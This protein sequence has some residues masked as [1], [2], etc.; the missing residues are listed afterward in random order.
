MKTLR[1]LVLGLLAMAVMQPSAGLAQTGQPASPVAEVVTPE[2]QA[3]ARGLQND[4]VQIFNFVHD[5]IR[6]VFYFGSKKGAEITLLEKSGN[7]FDQCAL[8]VALLRAAGYSPSYEFGVLEMPYDATDGTHN[9][10]HHWL[11]L[12]LVNTNWSNTLDYFGSLIGQRGYP[13]FLDF[14]DGNT[15]G[16]QRVWVVVVI[17]GTTYHLDPGFKVSEPVAGISLTNATG[18]STSGLLSAAGGTDTGNYVTNLNEANIRATLTGYTTNLLN[19]LQNNTPN[20]SVQ[21]VLGGWQIVPATNT[22]LSQNLLFDEDSIDLPIVGWSNE[23]TNLMTSFSIAFAGTNYQWRMPQLEGQRISLTYS[24]NGV[25]QLW[26]DDSLLVQKSTVASDT[27]FVLTINHPFGYWDYTTNGLVDTGLDDQATT[28]VCQRTSSTYVMA[29]AFEPDW[30]WLHK[31]QNQLDAYRMSGMTNGSRQVVSET[32]NILGLSWV[33][34]TADVNQI[35]ASQMSML[36]QNHHTIGRVGQE[37]AGFFID[38]HKNSGDFP[39]SGI[40]DAVSQDNSIREPDLAAYFSSA[41]ESGIIEQLQPTN[42]A[43]STVKMLEIANTNHQAVFLASI[44][45]WATG[46]NV[47]NQLLGYDAG[48][49]SLLTA[50]VNAGFYI[51]LPKSGTN[52]VGGTGSWAGYGLVARY[53]NSTNLNESLSMLITGGYNGGYS[54][55]SSGIDPDAVDIFDDSYWDYFLT[56]PPWTPDPTGADPVD[57]SDGTFQVEHTDLSIGQTE[58]RGITLTRYYNGA[59]RNSNPV[60]MAGGWLHNY[61]INATTVAA[62][63][64]ALGGMSPQHMASMIAAAYAAAN[65]YSSTPNAKNWMVTALVAKW[66]IDQLKNNG[67]SVAMGKDVVEF[68]KQPNGIFSPPGNCTMTLTQTNSAYNLQERHGNTFK[69]DSLGRLTNIVDQYSQPLTISYNAS[70][71]VSTVKDWKSRTFTFNYSGTPQRLTSVSDGTRTINYGYGTTYSAQGD[72]ISFTD[73]ESKTTTYTY[74]TNHQ[75][76][77]TLDGLSRLVVSNLYDSQGHITTQYTQ[78]DTNKTWQI[79][80]SGWQTAEQDPAGSQRIFFYDDQARLIGVQDQLLHL[81]QTLYD[82]QNHLTMTVSPL[83]ETNQYIYDSNNNLTY[84]VDPLG[85]TNQYLYDNQNNLVKTIDPRG[86]ISTFGYNSQFSLTG[87]TNGAGDFVTS[88]YNSDGTLAN[89]TDSG[90]T[91][92]FNYDA[93]GQLNLVTYPS[94]LGSESFGNSVRGDVTNHTDARNFATA[95]QYNNRRELTNTIA[96]TNLMVKVSFDAA[97][98]VANITDPRGNTATRTWSA[99]RH[100]LATTM[101]PTPQ[102]TPVVTNSY[103]SRDWLI[104]M[105]DP[106]QNPVLY[107]ND[108]TGRL[109]SKTDPAQRTTTFSYD[110]DG[111]KLTSV[112]A[113]GET[114]SQTWDVRGG[115]LKLTDGA[116]HFSTRAYDAAGNQIILTNRNGKKWQFQFDGANRLTNTITPLGHSTSRAFNHQGLVASL[117]DPAGQ[118]TS[119]GYDAKGRLTNRTDNIATTLLSYDAN[120]NRTSVIESSKTNAWTYDAYNRISTYR[121]TSGNL[122]QYRYDANGNVTNLIYPGNRTV[123]YFYDSVNR[124]TNVMDWSGRKTSFAYDLNNRVTSIIRPNGTFRTINYDAAGQTTN[125]LEQTAIG[126]PIALFR[127]NWNTAAE[128]QWEFAAPLPHTNAPPTRTMTYNDDNQLATFN[129][130]PVTSDFDGNLT[131][132]PLTNSTFVTYTYDIRNRLSDAG[133]VT[134]SYDAMNS[135]IG[136]TYGTNAA[137]FVINPN[138][139]LPQVLMRI[140][141]GVTNYYIYGLGLLY[142]ITETT[143]TTNTLTYHYDYR[144]STIALSADNGLVTDRIEYSLYGSTTYR[145]GTNDTPFL[146]NGRYGVQTDPNGLL[147]MRA[148]YYNPYLCRFLNP[149]PTGFSGGMNFYT[150]ANGN[151]VNLID[152]FGLG[153]TEPSGNSWLGDIFR[154]IPIIGGLLGGVGDVLSGVGN[155]L[156]GLGTFGQSG[157]LNTGLNQFGQGLANSII[158]SVNLVGSVWTLPNTAIGFVAGGVSFLAGEVMGTHPEFHIANNAFQFLNLPFGPGGAL[159]LGNTQLYNNA[160]PTTTGPRYDGGLGDVVFG[161]HEEGHT[162]Q[163]ELLGPFFLPVYF[164]SGGISANNPLENSADDYSQGVGSWWPW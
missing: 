37:S 42:T 78:G 58:P 105:V 66:G 161:P 91:T 102:G 2:I 3:L 45:N 35:L 119:L 143:T 151:P 147:Y 21:Q 53:F 60:G 141:N 137:T 63:W 1:I 68:V 134:N 28:N 16:I 112:N 160:D 5:H 162:Y 73:A 43:A 48:T 123:T 113:A 96:P 31:R 103:D 135:R 142:Q 11:Q 90:G 100:L 99:T 86:N 69:F 114:N 67:V 29:Y 56:T 20:A 92:Q 32:L 76:T 25:A 149:D 61:N 34:E 106:L 131:S 118:T 87:Q 153:A 128:A 145:A 8:L 81:T 156:L 62:P 83:N 132:A 110:A 138:T 26:Q 4:P 111:R 80:W 75:I 93:N 24:N 70:N 117:K 152:P 95:F 17:G 108:V 157:T 22:V 44:T 47:Q 40:D 126:F 36:S 57:M 74:D 71:W 164:I 133:G 121:D 18:F 41:L 140:K 129:G 144:G 79:F 150:Y 72:L 14:G 136:Q 115:M 10:L 159:T 12:T 109:I 155:T 9:D 124:L 122:I 54:G 130:S 50:Y 6:Q 39:N 163:Y 33:L 46:A 104:R 55:G 30:S 98:N 65:I 82:G 77:A 120:D 38:I 23:P 49:K 158:G 94:S 85:F 107:T 84:S 27:N 51:L 127:L 15:L 7:D 101:P 154:N 52:R 59:R 139:R 19:Y 88:A 148:R 146:F 13:T 97:D 125:V 116:G 89:R 64:P